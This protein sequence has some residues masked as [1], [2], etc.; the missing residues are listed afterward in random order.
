ASPCLAGLRR[1]S[2]KKCGLTDDALAALAESAQLRPCK[3]DLYENPFGPPGLIAL[4]GSP[5]LERL[6]ELNL[7]FLPVGDAGVAA[8]A[9]SPHARSMRRLELLKCNLSDD[10]ALALARSGWTTLRHLGMASNAIT[11]VGG[12]ALANSPVLDRVRE[13]ELGSTQVS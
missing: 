9:G 1:L 3:L 13:L 5:V 10:S 2:L 8:L 4:A 6:G 7:D 12:A 11:D